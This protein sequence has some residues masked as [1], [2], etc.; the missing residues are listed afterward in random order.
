MN[1]A[2]PN[3]RIRLIIPRHAQEQCS[4][5]ISPT[6]DLRRAVRAY[7]QCLNQLVPSDSVSPK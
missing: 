3:S 2:P 7:G 5:R 4:K 1:L 6:L